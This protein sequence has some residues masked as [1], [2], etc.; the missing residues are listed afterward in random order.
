MWITRGC[1]GAKRSDAAVRALRVDASEDHG[2]L[3]GEAFSSSGRKR[4]SPRSPGTAISNFAAAEPNLLD[5]AL[6]R[7]KR[8]VYVVGQHS[9]WSPRGTSTVWRANLRW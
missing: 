8:R 7:A 5:V 1:A 9:Q 4:F 2:R 6:T 3:F